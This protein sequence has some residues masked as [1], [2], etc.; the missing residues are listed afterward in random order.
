M[1]YFS[2]EISSHPQL[3]LAAKSNLKTGDMDESGI[4]FLSYPEV[5]TK[6]SF[7]LIQKNSL[8]LQDLNTFPVAHLHALLAGNQVPAANYVHRHHSSTESY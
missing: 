6:N 2:Q 7:H 4:Q 5:Y 3:L 8:W 1:Q